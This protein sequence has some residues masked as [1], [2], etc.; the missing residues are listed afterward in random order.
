MLNLPILTSL[1]TQ[2]FGQRF[3]TNCDCFWNFFHST[4]GTMDW[5]ILICLTLLTRDVTTLSH[6][7][8]L[9]LALCHLIRNTP[10]Y[11]KYGL[12]EEAKCLTRVKVADSIACLRDADNEV[13][14]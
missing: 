11:P 5:V 8:S 3:I 2:N 7:D 12:H 4:P 14:T 13:K 6:T 9:E 10:Y 1:N